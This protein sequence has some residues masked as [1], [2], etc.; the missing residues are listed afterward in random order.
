LSDN[1]MNGCVAYWPIWEGRGASQI[2]GVTGSGIIGTLTDMDPATDWVPSGDP[3]LGW[4]L[5]FDG[6][7][8]YLRMAGV[9]SALGTS[10][11]W[12]LSFWARL[13]ESPAL[14]NCFNL[15]TGSENI[16]IGYWWNSGNGFLLQRSDTSNKAYA[17]ELSAD[18]TITQLHHWL[19][20]WDG[21]AARCTIHVDAR[22]LSAAGSSAL[23]FYDVDTLDF[24]QGLG[25]AY[26]A[27]MTLANVG[28]WSRALAPSEI[29]QL[30]CESSRM[31]RMEGMM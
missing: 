26:E 4:A 3:R 1:L 25:G 22:D 13:N 10:T 20:R 23:T 28:L 27:A 11:P 9:G 24:S 19:I 29:Q 30:F 21:T 14:V 7:N 5:D 12:T 17:T 16:A 18:P 6:V 8:D 31:L 2:R 15:N